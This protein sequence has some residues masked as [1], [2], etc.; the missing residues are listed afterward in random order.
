MRSDLCEMV[1]DAADDN[2]EAR[3][4]YGLMAV[5]CLVGGLLYVWLVAS[6]GWVA[7]GIGTMFALLALDA[8]RT[9]RRLQREGGAL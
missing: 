3:W 1:Q 5:V 2:R 9:L 4:M 7:V 6:R 8:H